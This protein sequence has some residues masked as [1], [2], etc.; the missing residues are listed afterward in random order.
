VSQTRRS[1]GRLVL[2]SASERR[3]A[4]LRAAGYRFRISPASVAET[5]HP[6]ETA[7]RAAVRLARL[8]ALEVARRLPSGHVL[9]ADTLVAVGEA[10]LGK[11]RDRADAARMLRLLSGR[12]HRV[13]T[14]VAVCRAGGSGL[15]WGRRVTHVRFR[16]LSRE[17]IAWYVGTGEPLDKAGAYGIQ[18]R[19][20][21]LVEDVRG[22]YT[23]V[24]GLPM[25]TVRVLLGLPAQGGP[26]RR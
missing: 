26:P 9:A 20:A 3:A 14:G 15:R 21:L 16:R 17:E 19:A 5:L 18:G 7:S 1:N 22:S 24:V 2:A 25:E 12:T 8:K 11:P 23:N 6:G 4:L 10:I 13:V